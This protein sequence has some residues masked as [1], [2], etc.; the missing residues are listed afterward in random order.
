[1]PG[2]KTY[3]WAAGA[4]GLLLATLTV[5]AGLHGQ[6]AA[7]GKG[8]PAAP[9]SQVPPLAETGFQSMF[10]GRTLSGWDGDPDFWRVENGEIVGE[11]RQDHQPKQ[12]TFLVW[13]DGKP[14]DF[15][16]K[17]QYKLSG[18]QAN[19]GLQYRSVELPEVAR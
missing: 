8:A 2:S 18:A 9:P 3:R 5:A 13:R 10:D 7:A 19:S 11:T 12:N 6:P 1:M 17:M 4:F 16:M 14:A 15:E